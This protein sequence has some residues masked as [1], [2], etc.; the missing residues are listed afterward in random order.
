MALRNQAAGFGRAENASCTGALQASEGLRLM[1]VP[2]S[3]FEAALQLQI[4]A[5][6]SGESA[7]GREG[8]PEPDAAA[9]RRSGQPV[10]AGQAAAAAP[11]PRRGHLPGRG[12]VHSTRA[13]HAG[14]GRPPAPPA[15]GR[16]SPPRPPPRSGT[17]TFTLAPAAG[18]PARGGWASRGA[19]VSAPAARGA[20]SRRRPSPRAPPQLAHTRPDR[21][22]ST[23]SSSSSTPWPSP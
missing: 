4:R 11:C 10:A 3:L 18:T 16:P 20:R 2:R 6:A 21:P 22:I 15:A 23:P 1:R 13:Q 8:Q 19:F 9:A 12:T 5:V 17:D 14:A 7:C